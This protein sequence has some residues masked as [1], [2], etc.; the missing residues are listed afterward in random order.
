MLPGM[1]DERTRWI[2]IWRWRLRYGWI[3]GKLEFGPD[4]D[5]RE[6]VTKVILSQRMSHLLWL[7][8][9]DCGLWIEDHR[10]YLLCS[11]SGYFA[12]LYNVLKIHFE[13]L[14]GMMAT[15]ERVVRGID[16][17]SGLCNLPCVFK[18]RASVVEEPSSARSSRLCFFECASLTR[19]CIKSS[20]IWK[21]LSRVG[22]FTL[23]PSSM[24]FVPRDSLPNEYR[25]TRNEKDYGE[26]LSVVSYRSFKRYHR[27]VGWFDI[28]FRRRI[29]GMSGPLPTRMSWCFLWSEDWS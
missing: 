9:P 5:P 4:I 24:L 12:S 19:L 23:P 13:L 6:D 25:R 8:P 1:V 11:S 3:E 14:H 7:D 2:W 27:V 15:T 10:K 26:A 28:Q 22:A 20:L 21:L 17:G 29:W 18:Y 16:Y